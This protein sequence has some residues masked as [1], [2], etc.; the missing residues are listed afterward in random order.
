[1]LMNNNVVENIIASVIASIIFVILSTVLG[2]ILFRLGVSNQASVFIGLLTLLF[3]MLLFLAFKSVYPA[4]T[5]WLTNR[6]LERALTVDP[7]E[8]DE[9]KLALRG[10]IL[11]RVYHENPVA[12]RQHSGTVVEYEN[13]LACEAFIQAE[14]QRAR[15]I[16]ILTI[17][18]A[19]YFDG[20]KSLFDKLLPKKQ[21]QN[22]IIEVLVLKP[23]AEHITD[24]LANDLGQ[25]SAKQVQ[26]KMKSV[27]ETLKDIASENRNFEVKCYEET[28]NFKIL[29]FDDVMFVSS[30][31]GANNDQQ[32]KMLRILR[33]DNPLFMGLERY[34]DSLWLRSSFPDE[35]M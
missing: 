35:D 4:Y 34:F 19:K 14:F 22:Y 27:L 24:K 1:M 25:R 6:L 31:I 15:T 13:Q 17:R 3:L 2:Y 20:P 32:V 21:T 8:K 33:A 30:F 5:R 10:K 7:K 26:R 12:E 28:P 9:A 18:G 29:M 23:E 16:K 11:E